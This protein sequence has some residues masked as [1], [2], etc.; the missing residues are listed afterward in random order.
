MNVAHADAPAVV[1]AF[2]NA[3]SDNINRIPNGSATTRGAQDCHSVSS[4]VTWVSASLIHKKLAP[5]KMPNATMNRDRDDARCQERKNNPVASNVTV[6][7]STSELAP[8]AP[9]ISAHN[10]TVSPVAATVATAA[11]RAVYGMRGIPSTASAATAPQRGPPIP[12]PCV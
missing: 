5:S 8:A 9:S 7:D 1:R 4:I 12:C 11:A 10:T 3:S 2:M 6:S